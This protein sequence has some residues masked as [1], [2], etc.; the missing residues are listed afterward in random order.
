MGNEGLKGYCE[1]DAV[2]LGFFGR[3]CKYWNW[4]GPMK[5]RCQSKYSV[6]VGFRCDSMAENYQRN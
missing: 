3:D 5:Q 4:D 2:D 1:V 6:F